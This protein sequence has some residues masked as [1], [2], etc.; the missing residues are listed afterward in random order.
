M[1]KIRIGRITGAQGLRGEVKI[2]HDSGD[3]EAL[4]RL[5]A[6]FIERGGALTAMPIESLRMKKRTPIL[7]LTGVDGRAEAEA[8]A[9]AAVYADEDESRPDAEGAWLVSDLL[10]LEVRLAADGQDGPDG[11]AGPGGGAAPW[12]VK[13][14]ISNPAHDILEIETGK[15]VC[16]LPFVD[17]FVLEVDTKS[18]YIIIIPPKGWMD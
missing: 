12:R 15:G 14:I 16:L 8:L 1:G 3:G 18:G 2:Y 6:V 17:A 11:P 9:G 4:G 5:S 10:G 7:K 13:N